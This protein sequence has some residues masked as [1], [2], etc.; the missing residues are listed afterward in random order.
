V[1]P[2]AW[3]RLQSGTADGGT[4][5]TVDFG[6]GRP[7]AGFPDLLER[8]PAD[9][10]VL[11]AVPPGRIV[12]DL[13]EV[14]Q[15]LAGWRDAV[16]RAD[17]RVVAVLG[18]CAGASIATCL[19][20]E[21]AS[22]LGP[23]K[24]VLLDPLRATPRLLQEAY[25]ASAGTFSEMLDQPLGTRTAAPAV[26]HPDDGHRAGAGDAMVRLAGQLGADYAEAAERVGTELSLDAALVDDLVMRFHRYLSY[27]AVAGVA[28]ETQ[29]DAAEPTGPSPPTLTITSAD[30]PNGAAPPAGRHVG[31]DVPRAGLLASAGVGSA[32][33]EF[34]G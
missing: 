28:A 22:R 24:L 9:L 7:E 18:Y 16:P 17:G 13:A 14:S 21:L 27:L 26:P 8:L 23:Q 6:G 34:I 19:A 15:Q 2:A 20:R 10:T 25:R 32:I 3:H 33:M 1:D 5:L 30:H 12:R 29:L 11:A 31:F 4:V